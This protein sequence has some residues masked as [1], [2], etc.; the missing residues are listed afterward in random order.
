MTLRNAVQ[1]HAQTLMYQDARPKLIGP[2]VK[3]CGQI[4]LHMIG[5]Q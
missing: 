4:I 2:G 5:M 3:F 1:E